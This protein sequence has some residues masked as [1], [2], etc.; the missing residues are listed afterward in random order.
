MWNFKMNG[1]N[2]Y[3]DFEF[4]K[5]VFSTNNKKWNV[6]KIVNFE[7]KTSYY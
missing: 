5:Q 4:R 2:E 6:I 7:W 3:M 1:N